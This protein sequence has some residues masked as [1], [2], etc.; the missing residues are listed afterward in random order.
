MKKQAKPYY[1]VKNSTKRI[2]VLQGGTRSGK[3]YSILLALIEFAYKNK[4]K[5]LYI[6]IARQTFPSLR[7]TAMRDFFDILKNENLYNERN[8]NKS[9]HIYLLYGNYFEF[10]ST[11]SEIKIRGRQREVLF[12]NECNEFSMDTFLQLS[13]RTKFKIIIDFNPSEEFHWLYTHIIDADRDDVDF[14]ISTY[15][16]NPFLQEA[17]ISEIERLK[18]VDEN[19]YN[20][21]GKGLRGVSTETIFPSFNIVDKVPDNAKPIALGLD[22][23]YSAD[24][25][26]IVSVYKHDLDLYID[27][28]LYERG[29]TNQDIGAR[30]KDMK[31]ERGT[32]CFADSSE[33]K[34]IEELYR[35]NTGVNIKPAKKGADSIRI[36]IDVMKRHK[37]N[38]T[39]RSVNAIK[40][41]RNYKWIKDKNNEITNKPIDA[42]NH[43]I[44]AVRYVCLNKL[45]V[46]Y[47]GKYYI[48]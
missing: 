30:I 9:N 6:T 22:F 8:H 39:K 2:C 31:I 25:T 28:L 33:P 42:F 26:T 16:D 41:F 20:V 29:L 32:E 36:G 45:M 27:E 13:L 1:D 21:F 7:A 11:D 34:S 46:S 4:G 43:A 15:K 3:T 10:I 24:P 17:T 40:E 18:E 38:I 44:D 23:G 47:S 5:G 12:L 48:S 14:H 19:L 37:L 35:M